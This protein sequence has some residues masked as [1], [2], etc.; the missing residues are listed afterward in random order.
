MIKKN[1]IPN[2]NTNGG[3][4]MKTENKTLDEAIHDL[5]NI[6]IQSGIKP[7]RLLTIMKIIDVYA[8]VKTI[9]IAEESEKRLRIESRNELKDVY[10]MAY[11]DGA[12]DMVSRIKQLT[13][14]K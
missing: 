11:L 7:A 8:D 4:E 6:L 12:S 10:T 3:T 2:Q 14:E 5:H 13:E 9:H 1:P